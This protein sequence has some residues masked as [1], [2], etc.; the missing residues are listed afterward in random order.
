MRWVGWGQ[1]A[2]QRDFLAARD[3]LRRF[4]L[5]PADACGSGARLG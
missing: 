5:G 3:E 2:E 1:V 4:V